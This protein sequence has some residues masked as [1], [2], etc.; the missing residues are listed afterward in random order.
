M[1]SLVFDSGPIIS[2]TLNNLLWLLPPLKKKFNGRFIIAGET[3]KELVDRP[4]ASKKFK[5]E[6]YQIIE[7]LSQGILE[8]EE[9]NKTETDRILEIANSCFSCNN[10]DI[11]IIHRADA[12]GLILTKQQSLKCFVVD[13][14]TERLLIENPLRLRQVLE[15]RLQKRLSMNEEAIDKFIAY[16]KGVTLLRSTEIATIAFELGL[17]DKYAVNGKRDVLDAVLWGL[18]LN[19]CSIS[20]EEIQDILRIEKA[21][22]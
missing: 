13:E 20:R 6:A 15:R 14:R 3:K 2:F 17:L 11:Q 5:F 12:E 10:Q 19:G 4:L 22:A 16:A 18:K 7:L 9:I 21:R 1:R 8:V